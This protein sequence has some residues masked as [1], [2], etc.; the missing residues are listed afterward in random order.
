MSPDICLTFVENHKILRI[1]DWMDHEWFLL[2]V[3]V[4]LKDDKK[5]VYPGELA[6]AKFSVKEGIIDTLYMVRT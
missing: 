3:A 4:F 6:I 1:S 2:S 5:N